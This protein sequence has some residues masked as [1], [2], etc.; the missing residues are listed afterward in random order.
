M[1]EARKNATAPVI[2]LHP[3]LMCSTCGL[4]DRLHG[5]GA[6][7]EPL[8]DSIPMF[9]AAGRL[10][11]AAQILSEPSTAGACADG[12]ACGR[13]AAV[14]AGPFTFPAR[15]S[16]TP[17]VVA[18]PGSPVVCTLDADG[19]DLVGRVEQWRSILSQA[20]GRETVEGGL[21]VTFEHDIARTAELARLLASEYA[22]CSF[23]SYHLTIDDRG[24]RMEIHAP[25]DGLDALEAVFGPAR[26]T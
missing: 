22:S 19:G 1:P 24:V 15:D 16:T 2:E 5:A 14:T 12:C 3:P 9:K 10:R 18:S 17:V 23:A 20:T 4:R 6:D 21:A 13:A 11:A 7:G 25:P 26:A 8:R